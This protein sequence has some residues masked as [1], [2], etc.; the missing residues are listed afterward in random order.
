VDPS[1]GGTPGPNALDLAALLIVIVAM[2]LG[3]RSGF[4]PQLGGLLG[5]VAGGG[6]ALLALP[7]VQPSIKE[8]EPPVRALVVLAGLIF[9]IG[10]GEAVGSAS[11][12]AVHSRL[13]A[14]IL[15]GAN[16]VA[17]A[18]LGAA[19]GLLVVW[20]A[21]GI[22]A[23]GP[24]PNLAP[25]AQTS[26]TVR[27]LSSYLPQPT[28]IA[29]NLGRLLDASGLPEVFVGLEPFPATPV[30][31]PSTQEATRIAA[32]AFAS[33]VKVTADACDF[34]LSGTGFA[35][36]RGYFVTNAHVVAG[37]KNE[38]VALDNG[39]HSSATVV[40]FDPAL[41]I[42]LLYAP[43]MPTPILRFASQD[44]A[45]GARGAALGHPLGRPLTVIPAGVAGRY[46]AEGRD[47]YGEKTVTRM[48]LELSARIDRGD[49][50]G[51]L[52][53]TDGTVG[54]VIFAEAKSDVQVGYALTPIE[55]SKRVLPALGRTKAVSTGGCAR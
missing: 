54:G 20:L 26:W 52:I 23:A 5:A 31:T 1:A 25:V 33:T 28:V 32:S 44:P 55:V 7:V 14:G 11:G 17:G 9:A 19:Q 39:V 13:R 49:S 50:G 41:D 6:L 27:Q 45:T 24:I 22:L 15:G 2:A 38:Q 34:E 46:P 29:A 51:P 35:I 42:A 43:N 18:I 4:F 12:R 16:Q 8:M 53:L 40:L 21:G 3:A 30:D 48:I 10:I 47:I 37:G 36:R